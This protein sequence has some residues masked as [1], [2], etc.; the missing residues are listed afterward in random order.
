LDTGDEFLVFEIIFHR[1]NIEFQAKRSR[2]PSCVVPNKRGELAIGFKSNHIVQ[3]DSIWAL[4]N[5]RLTARRGFP[6]KGT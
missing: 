6:S 3:G 5:S 1:E 2:E 4:S